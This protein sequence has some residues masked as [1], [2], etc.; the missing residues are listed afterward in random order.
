ME[1][2]NSQQEGKV[3]IVTGGGSGIGWAIAKKLADEKF[4]TI[5][6]GRDAQKLEAAKQTIGCNI[7]PIVFDLTNLAGIPQM[8]DAIFH[9]FGRV[10]VLVNNAGINMKKEFL[11]VTDAD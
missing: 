9:Q 7:H 1:N 4:T 2:K 10:D 11:E 5:I 3:A 8:V 6:I